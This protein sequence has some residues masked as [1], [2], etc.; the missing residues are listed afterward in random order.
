MKIL[1][2]L[3]VGTL[4]LAAPA[5]AVTRRDDV[6]EA[7][8]IALASSLPVFSSVGN[9]S[10]FGS[11]VLISPTWVLTAAHC[12]VLN[13]SVF[14]LGSTTYTVNQTIVHP[15]YTG[16]IENG[17]DIALVRLS[18]PV[19]DIA[20]APL[21]TGTDELGKLGYHVGYGYQGVGSTGH[22]GSGFGTKRAVQNIAEALGG[23]VPVAN[24]NPR[25]SDDY[26]IA[27]FDTPTGTPTRL[28]A[29]GSDT[30]LPFEGSIAP[31]DSG[32][33]FF[34]QDSQGVWRV[35]GIHSWIDGVLPGGDGSDN[36]SYTDLM[37][38]TR[39]STYNSWILAN[40][41]PE[42]SSLALLALP[43]LGA[44]GLYRRNRAS[45]S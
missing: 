5:Q 3:A 39:V 17:F 9:L 12:A 25:F 26:L 8:T 18:T 29:Y 34:V 10:N 2:F 24:G 42:P 15:G 36:A 6:S 37:G 45:H 23:V 40:A 13:P 7:Q 19:L 4:A 20:G 32:G 27:D 38:S 44:V 22:T 16:S 30:A 35:A 28:S 1:W 31:G 14:T 33:G 43:M 21:Y 41:A 11:G